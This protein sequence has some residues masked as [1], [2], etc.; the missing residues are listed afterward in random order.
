MTISKHGSFY[1]YSNKKKY[2]GVS[3][4]KNKRKFSNNGV[5]KALKIRKLVV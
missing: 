3:S 2:D 1:S 5:T 4:M